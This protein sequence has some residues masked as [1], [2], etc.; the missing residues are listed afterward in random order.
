[1]RP[2]GGPEGQQRHLLSWHHPQVPTREHSLWHRCFAK[3]GGNGNFLKRLTHW[4]SSPSQPLPLF[5]VVRKTFMNWG[6]Q[7]SHSPP[8]EGESSSV[9][10]PVRSPQ[11]PGLPWQVSA[12]PSCC[13]AV[14][15][16]EK[17]M[18]PG[19]GGVPRAH[20]VGDGAP[21][22]PGTCLGFAPAVC[23][24]GTLSLVSELIATNGCLVPGWP[25]L[26]QS[27]RARHEIVLESVRFISK[28]VRV[29]TPG[30][31]KTKQQVFCGVF[32]F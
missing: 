7:D 12:V 29:N 4:G 22:S 28:S 21:G 9:S 2:R 13:C 23:L 30:Q 20:M 10:V 18:G 14:G 1:M 19:V 16:T 32:F 15:L 8:G 17:T 3:H 24:V 5:C 6:Y 25:L 26:N 11:T 27:L 31:L